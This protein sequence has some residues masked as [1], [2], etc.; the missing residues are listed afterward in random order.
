MA[1]FLFKL[2]LF[3]LEQKINLNVMNQYVKIIAF[4][5]ALL[6]SKDNILKFNQC[7]KSDKIPSIIYA[8][9]ES[10]IKII[11]NCK[12]NTEKYSTKK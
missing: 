2:S 8:G 1:V 7:R 11:E 10:L 5:I 3:S 9:L 4:G 6:T 12:S